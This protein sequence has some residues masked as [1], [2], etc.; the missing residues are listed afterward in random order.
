MEIEII[1]PKHEIVDEINSQAILKKIE[2][3]GRVSHKS[4]DRTAPGTA[5]EFIK[6]LLGWGHESILEHVSFTVKFICDRGVT[7]ELVRHRIAAYTQESTRYCNYSGK[8]QF[9]KPLFFKED[10]EAYRLWLESCEACASSYLKLISSGAKPEEARDVLSNSLKT[11]I[12]ATYNLR[13]WRHVF[14]MRCQKAAHPQIREIMIPLLEELQKKIPVIFD[15][16]EIITIDDSYPKA[17]I[18]KV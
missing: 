8:I 17:A 11:E 14:K 3:I 6:K 9:I 18:K 12:Y 2:R 4:E 5:E 1:E 15:D 7:H 16:F 10:S 13:E